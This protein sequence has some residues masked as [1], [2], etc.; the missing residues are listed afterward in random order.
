MHTYYFQQYRLELA[1]AA[2]SMALKIAAA[3]WWG[4]AALQAHALFSA[5][6][7]VTVLVVTPGPAVEAG[8]ARQTYLRRAIAVLSAALLLTA[9]GIYLLGIAAAGFFAAAPGDH[10]KLPA[11]MLTGLALALGETALYCRLA[12]RSRRRR[13]LATAAIAGHFRKSIYLFVPVFAAPALRWYGYG[14]ADGIFGAVL[15]LYLSLHLL[16]MLRDLLGFAEGNSLPGIMLHELK[17]AILKVD[18]VLTVRKIEGR[19]EG[20]GMVLRL[21]LVSKEGLDRKEQ[22]RLRETVRQVLLHNFEALSLV[23]CAV[24]TLMLQR[25]LLMRSK[26]SR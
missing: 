26:Q 1:A 20:E 18:G 12:E 9:F 14:Y 23:Y 4:S 11:L 13:C 6:G 5:L 2:L 25:A 17:R 3:V 21:Q 15:L 8:R 10:Y 16:E 24:S 19:M 7:L 22:D